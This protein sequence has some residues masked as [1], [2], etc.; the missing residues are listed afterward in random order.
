M[1]RTLEGLQNPGAQRASEENLVNLE[2][3]DDIVFIFE[4]KEKAHVFL[5]ELIK[6]IPSFDMHFAPK[7]CKVI[8]LRSSN[9]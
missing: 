2:Y 1:R 5:D 8:S 9:E 6:F 4:E 7:N 3:A